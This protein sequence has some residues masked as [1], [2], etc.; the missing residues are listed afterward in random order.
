MGDSVRH[1][2]YDKGAE[3][4]GQAHRRRAH[5]PPGLWC[6]RCL[7]WMVA[8]GLGSSVE[9]ENPSIC[10]SYNGDFSCGHSGTNLLVKSF[11][12]HWVPERVSEAIGR[13][14][15]LCLFFFFFF[16]RTTSWKIKDLDK[17]GEMGWLEAW[18]GREVFVIS[19]LFFLAWK[20]LGRNKKKKKKKEKEKKELPLWLSRKEPD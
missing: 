13:V 14:Q 7:A 12:G 3:I 18:L 16:A 10:Q 8:C 17:Q 6:S 1:L 20:N 2:K 5:G 9:L 4:V 15:R 19:L 11:A